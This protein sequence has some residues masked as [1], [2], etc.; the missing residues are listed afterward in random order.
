MV[1]MCL[2]VCL[3]VCASVCLSPPRSLDHQCCCMT[4]KERGEQEGQERLALYH[5][6]TSRCLVRR[7]KEHFDGQA[8]KKKDNPLWKHQEMFHAKDKEECKF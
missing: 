7:Q 2:C 5:G 4:C 1:L 6:Q 3:S 8:A